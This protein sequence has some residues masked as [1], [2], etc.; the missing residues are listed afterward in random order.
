LHRHNK[1]D[2]AS[3]EGELLREARVGHLATCDISLNPHV[4]PICYVFY[5]DAIYCAVDE[6]PKR[7]RPEN[8]RRIINIKA[9][10]NV[11]VVVDHYEEDWRKL[12]F[13]IVHGKA[14]LILSGREHQQAVT[15]LRNKYPQYRIMN[16]PARPIIR[17]IP[18]RS[19]AWRPDKRS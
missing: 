16:L 1:G 2:V 8:L 9:N 15:Q 19:V 18:T 12:K 6:K 11:C 7:R 17:I 13:I 3:W 14:K 4:V 5:D 10:P